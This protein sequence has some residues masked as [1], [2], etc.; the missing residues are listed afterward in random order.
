MDYA[1]AWLGSLDT[2]EL[3]E[4]LFLPRRFSSIRM[5]PFLS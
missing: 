5:S 3:F 2:K 1:L 4:L